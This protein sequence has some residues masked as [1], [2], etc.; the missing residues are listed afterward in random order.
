[1]AA[2]GNLDI[3]GSIGGRLRAL[4]GNIRIHSMITGDTVVA[5]GNIDIRKDS[6]ISKDLVVAAGNVYMDGT[7]KGK[8]QI[9]AGKV[10]LNGIIEKDVKI[11]AEEIIVGSG[12]Q[13]R[14]NLVYEST[15]ANPALEGIVSGTKQFSQSPIKT[16][17]LKDI[18]TNVLKFIFSYILLK[19]LFLTVFGF[20]L[21]SFMEKYIHE[22]SGIVTK[23]PWVSLFTGIAFFVLVPIIALLLVFTLI[24]IPVAILMMTVLVCLFTFY[25]LIGT[26]IWAS[27]AIDRYIKVK[28]QN[29]SKWRKLL[30]IFGFALLFGIISGIDIIPAWMAIGAL[31]TR[32]WRLIESIRK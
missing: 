7:V 32:H 18:K 14:G 2:G 24:G 29:D 16:K 5:G 9:M 13:I 20:I 19:I 17:E 11:V 26:V 23:S 22:V 1:M 21:Y 6:I 10:Y 3:G 31:L 15:K 25:E 4:G 8:A 28:G 27:W 12:A 30:V